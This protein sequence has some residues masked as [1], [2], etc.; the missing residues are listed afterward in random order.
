VV[1][2]QRLAAL[3]LLVMG[4]ASLGLTR[5][6]FVL[7]ELWAGML[8]ALSFG[9]HRPGKWAASLCVA[10]LAIAIR[11][12]ALPFVLL[13]AAFAGWRRDWKESAA[14]SAL[15][16]VFLAGL[17]VHIHLVNAMIRPGDLASPPWLVL[18]GFAG[19]I[20]DYSQASNLRLVPGILAGPVVLLTL[21]GWVSW[22]SDA[23]AFGALLY[24]G[25]GLLFMIA[26][27]EGNWYWGFMV[28]PVFFIGLAFAPCGIWTLLTISAAK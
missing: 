16:A 3:V 14:W 22:R 10:A 13:M 20:G 19:L 9:L 4:G 6:F 1:R 8:L 5:H 11:E 2:S 17:A 26:G 24:L 28:T 21:F 7:H 18:R 15:A 25:Y 12:H 27:R 23:G